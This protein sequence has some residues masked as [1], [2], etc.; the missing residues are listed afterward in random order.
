MSEHLP[1][2]EPDLQLPDGSFIACICDRLRACE[3]RL[4]VD[5]TQHWHSA[6]ASGL[7]DGD[8]GGRRE[9]YRNGMAY[10]RARIRK[11]LEPL[12]LGSCRVYYPAGR[13]TCGINEVVD[14]GGI[15]E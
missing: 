6:Y 2:C 14:N 4:F 5:R 8:A 15:H 1:E 13:C 11:A 12:H 7:I 3:Q 9:G 10:E